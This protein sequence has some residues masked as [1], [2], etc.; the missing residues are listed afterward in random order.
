[1]RGRG[2]ILHVRSE[3]RGVGGRTLGL[4]ALDPVREEDVGVGEVGGE[5]GQRPSLKHVNI[6]A[7]TSF[8]PL[9]KSFTGV[10]NYL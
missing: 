10:K 4:P 6:R 5:R 2:D 7:H 8:D 9:I 1:M 3:D